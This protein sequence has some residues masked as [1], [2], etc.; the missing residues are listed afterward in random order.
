MPHIFTRWAGI[1]VAVFVVLAGRQAAADNY[2]SRP[3]R[4]IV[5]TQAGAA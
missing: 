3:I 5:P 4:L 1:V 2:P